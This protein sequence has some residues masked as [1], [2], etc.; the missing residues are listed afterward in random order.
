MPSTEPPLQNL[1][2]TTLRLICFSSGSFTC[3]CAHTSGLLSCFLLSTSSTYRLRTFATLTRPSLFM[4]VQLLARWHGTS[5]RYTGP[6]LLQSARHTLRV[7]SWLIFPS[8]V[9]WGTAC[10][11]SQLIKTTQLDL[12]SFY[13]QPVS[14]AA[15]RL[16]FPRIS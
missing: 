14:V 16:L 7:R 11:T 9:G 13:F 4:S 15:A 3:G 6:A 5:Q 2:P 8:G 10:F 12:P 1:A